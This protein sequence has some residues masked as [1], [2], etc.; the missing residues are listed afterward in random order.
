VGQKGWTTQ[1]WWIKSER[2][3]DACDKCF[4]AAR[5]ATSEDFALLIPHVST[6]AIDVFLGQF[7]QTPL[8]DTC[9]VIVLGRT[10]WHD[11]R[12]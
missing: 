2:A 5:A 3:L 7:A 1:G 9:P 8:D 10:D 6:A 11:M 4:A 12:A